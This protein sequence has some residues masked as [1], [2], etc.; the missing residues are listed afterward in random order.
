[1][2]ASKMPFGTIQTKTPLAQTAIFPSTGPLLSLSLGCHYS[3]IINE[4]NI[5]VG[6][7]RAQPTNQPTKGKKK[8]TKER[9]K[10]MYKWKVELAS[11]RRGRIKREGS[12]RE[13]KKG[14]Q[15]YLVIYSPTFP[16]TSLFPVESYST[17]LHP[18]GTGYIEFSAYP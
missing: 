14:T 9:K 1:M 17:G 12:S 10:S 18:T 4:G 8:K 3:I 13:K 11:G 15:L 6:G 7:G 5:L 2:N 16:T